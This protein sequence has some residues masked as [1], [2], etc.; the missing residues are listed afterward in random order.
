MK[1]ITPILFSLILTLSQLHAIDPLKMPKINDP[2]GVKVLV[3]GLG[4]DTVEDWNLSVSSIQTQCEKTLIRL[5]LEPSSKEPFIKGYLYVN[6]NTVAH[7]YS[8][9]VDYNRPLWVEEQGGHIHSTVWSKSMLG[10]DTS[11]NR[12][13]VFNSITEMTEMFATEYIKQNRRK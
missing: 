2:Q 6:V 11:Y 10:V 3:E 13:S 8:I 5:N 1:N 12:Q 7:A 4:R 9:S